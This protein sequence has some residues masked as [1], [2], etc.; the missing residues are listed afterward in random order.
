VV[1]DPV[2]GLVEGTSLSSST[3]MTI[4]IDSSVFMFSS[5]NFLEFIF[6]RGD[7]PRLSFKSDSICIIT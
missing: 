7:V 3:S 1:E 6:L 5:D 4:M 2:E